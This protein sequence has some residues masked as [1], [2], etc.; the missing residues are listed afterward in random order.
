MDTIDTPEQAAARPL[1][2]KL[3]DPQ[4]RRERAAKA[5]RAGTTLD[6]YVTRI[7]N[8]AGQLTPE[9]IARLRALLPP[10]ETR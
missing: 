7:V 10:A 9:Q 4:W 5:G 6:A 1:R 8:R 3:A 2:G